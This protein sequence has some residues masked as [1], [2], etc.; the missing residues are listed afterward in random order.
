MKSTL[1]SKISCSYFTKIHEDTTEAIKK[2]QLL[3]RYHR[4]AIRSAAK[5]A[6]VR[7]FIVFKI[8]SN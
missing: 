8:T 2:H 7:D 4:L 6:L 1:R 3:T 5:Q